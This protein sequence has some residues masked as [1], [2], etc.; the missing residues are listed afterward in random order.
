MPPK[1]TADR[2]D[3]VINLDA[4]GR[5][6]QAP[7]PKRWQLH[8]H[9][10]RLSKRQ[11]IVVAAFSAALIAAIV[12][13][14]MLFNRPAGAP[15][16]TYSTSNK[17]PSPLTGILV[18]PQLAKRPVTGIMIEN[19]L[20]ARPQSGLSDAGVVFEAIAEGGITRFLALFQETSPDYVGPVRSLRP[21]YLDWSTPF[22]ASIAH[23]GGSPEALNQIRSQGRD[24]DQF[25]NAGSYW[26]VADRISPHNVY[27]NFKELDKLNKAKGYKQS[28]FKSWL[29]KEPKPSH[30][31]RAKTINLAISGPEYNVR[32]VWSPSANSYKRQVGGQWHVSTAS[33]DPKSGEI[34]RPKVVIGLVVPY[35]IASDG[36]HSSYRTRG[37]GRAYIFQDGK[38]IKAIWRKADRLSQLRFIDRQRQPVALDTGQTWITVVGSSADVSFSRK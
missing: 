38:V 2:T 36:V 17:V 4:S 29:R 13:F 24:L 25:F 33:A 28:Q 22:Q 26:R 23:V 21:Y 27:T 16:K 11:K 34:I 32:Y 1:P 12:I 31:P 3:E 15:G 20:D 35:S 30:K 10:L 14:V 19:S 9:W 37:E 8:L 5:P 18:E 7:R 6:A